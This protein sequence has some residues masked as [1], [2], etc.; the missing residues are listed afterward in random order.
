MRAFTDALVTVLKWVGAFAIAGMML[1]VCADV[2]MR[3]LG[4]P[5]RGAVEITGFLAT[6]ALACS[7][8]FTHVVRGHVGVDMLVRKMPERHQAVVDSVTSALALVMFAIVSWR[9]FVYG[10]NL[11]ATGEV[12]M[13]LG[14]P[15]YY[16]VYFIGVAFIVLCLC[17]ARDLSR[18]FKRAVGR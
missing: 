1:M 11:K 2:I 6:T 7:L 16:F 4:T 18:Y 13:T 8:P 14:M 5:I 17:L 3:A 15:T 12:S 9:C 10:A